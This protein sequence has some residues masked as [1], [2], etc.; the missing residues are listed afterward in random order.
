MK[1]ICTIARNVLP[2]LMAAKAKKELEF[3]TPEDWAVMKPSTPCGQLPVL[4]LADGT[5]LAQ[6]TCVLLG[7]RMEF[8]T[9]RFGGKGE[10]RYDF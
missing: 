4:E 8:G 7:Q 9:Y 2:G 3:V 10:R 5:F 1:Q 6:S